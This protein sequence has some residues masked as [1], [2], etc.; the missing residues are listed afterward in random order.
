MDWVCFCQYGDSYLYRPPRQQASEVLFPFDI[1]E[2][3]FVRLQALQPMPCV[4]MRQMCEKSG[5][6]QSQSD[7]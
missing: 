5:T 1:L 4:V 7:L 3:L 2:S 6:A